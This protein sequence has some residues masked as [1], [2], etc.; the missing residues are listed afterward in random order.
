MQCDAMGNN[1]NKTM[2]NLITSYSLVDK[3][4]GRFSKYFLWIIQLIFQ[5]PVKS[6]RL[7]FLIKI[8][9]MMILI[10]W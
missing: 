10:T 4:F 6:S 2:N 5:F 7:F 3:I 8:M 9:S 1:C